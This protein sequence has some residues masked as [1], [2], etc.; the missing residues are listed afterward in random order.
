MHWS[1]HMVDDTVGWA[2]LVSRPCYQH[3]VGRVSGRLTPEQRFAWALAVAKSFQL[4]PL[5]SRKR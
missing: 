2:Q 3:V 5:H 4:K 1:K